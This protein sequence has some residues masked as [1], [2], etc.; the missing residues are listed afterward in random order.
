MIEEWMWLIWLAVFVAALVFEAMGTEII[1]IWFAGGAIV[2]MIMS[3]IPGVEWWLQLIVFVVV[4]VALLIFM[5][6]VLSKMVKRDIIPSNADTMVGKKGTVKV[7]ITALNHGEVEVDG[8]VWT[9][10][11]TKDGEE[12]AEGAVVKVLSISGNKLIVTLNK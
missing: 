8:V 1:S 10:I 9:A 4:S 2:A 11:S 7:A 6:P 12:I 5:R 3:F